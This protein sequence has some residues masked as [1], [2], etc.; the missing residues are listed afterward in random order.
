MIAWVLGGGGC[1][2]QREGLQRL[3]WKLVGG[4]DTFT[5][6]TMVCVCH[7]YGVCMHIK[8]HYTVYFKYVWFL[9]CPLYLSRAVIKA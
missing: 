8:T 5:V 3:V 2:V 4:M 7:T 6:S 9:A 1:R